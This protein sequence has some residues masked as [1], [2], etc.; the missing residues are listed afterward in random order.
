MEGSKK[1]GYTAPVHSARERWVRAMVVDHPVGLGRTQFERIL[2]I[3]RVYPRRRPAARVTAHQPADSH[4]QS[5]L[6]P[7]HTAQQSCSTHR[8]KVSL[9]LCSH[10]R[11][12]ALLA[13]LASKLLNANWWAC[14][15]A[16]PVA[17]NTW[18]K[19]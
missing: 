7:P 4:W 12:S 17:A 11:L 6:C 18:V 14:F 16:R 13:K 15:A 1:G 2:T 10:T 19:F 9:S 8:S 5:A 3:L